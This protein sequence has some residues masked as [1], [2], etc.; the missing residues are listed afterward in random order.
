MAEDNKWVEDRKYVLEFI[1]DTKK[2]LTEL[3]D[4]D[5]KMKTTIAVLNTKLMALTFVGSSVVSVIVSFI[6]KAAI[7]VG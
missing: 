7:G 1:N 3:A 5:T 2:Q 4:N 6:T